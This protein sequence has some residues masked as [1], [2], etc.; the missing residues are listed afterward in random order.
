MPSAQPLDESALDRVVADALRL[1]AI[2]APTFHESRRAEA[3]LDAL[4]EAGLAA[5]RDDAGNVV[6]RIGGDGPALAVCAHL[7]TVF[8]D[9]AVRVERDGIRLRG[10]GIGDNALGLAALLHVARDLAAHPPA[11]PVLLAATVGEEGLGDLRGVRHLLDAEP[12]A[13][14]IAVEGHGIDALGVG[15]IPSV[16]LEAVLRGPGGHSW[17]DRGRPSAIHALLD[18]GARLLDAAAPAAANIGLIEGGTAVNAIAERAALLVD[19]RHADPRV[20]DAAETRVRRVLDEPPRGIAVEVREAGRRPGGRLRPDAPLVL[21]ARAARADVG[22]GPA[23][24]HP[25]STDANAA[26]GR[27]IP[28]I[29]LGAS[30]GEHPHR[31]DEWIAIPPAALGVAAILRTVRRAAGGL[32]GEPESG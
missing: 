13:A 27:G 30:R 10:P 19:L 31:G 3:V 2:P 23:D 15:G 14:L 8:P 17:T 12:V 9:E 11:T 29:A 21:A 1:C 22:L 4:A 24:E 7:D 5:R 16:R 6:A 32:H 28:A 20:L 18:V 26:L 25:A